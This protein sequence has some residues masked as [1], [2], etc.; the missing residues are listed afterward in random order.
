MHSGTFPALGRTGCLMFTN[1]ASPSKNPHLYSWPFLFLLSHWETSFQ[2]I[3]FIQKNLLHRWC[4]NI[5]SSLAFNQHCRNPKQNILISRFLAWRISQKIQPSSPCKGL[6]YFVRNS[7]SLMIQQDFF[8]V[9]LNKNFIHWLWLLNMWMWRC[10]K[11]ACLLLL[12]RE[13]YSHCTKYSL[14]INL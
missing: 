6:K 14:V 13:Q 4:P 5:F 1:T 2:L 11:W 9:D 10:I 3:L 7:Y 12:L 8:S